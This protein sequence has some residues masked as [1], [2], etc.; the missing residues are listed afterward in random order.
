MYEYRIS[1][2]A[3]TRC[4]SSARQEKHRS[5]HTHTHTPMCEALGR[6][7]R[8]AGCIGA[9]HVSTES[10]RR[11]GRVGAPRE[12][13]SAECDRARPSPSSSSSSSSSSSTAAA[14]ETAA[15]AACGAAGA[16]GGAGVVYVEVAHLAAQ[17]DQVLHQ[18]L[19][20]RAHLLRLHRRLPVAHLHTLP[21]HLQRAHSCWHA[22]VHWCWCATPL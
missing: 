12:R 13:S 20:R 17:C 7:S 22:R 21:Q 14:A 2:T 3:A 18:T 1:G 16:R 9:E 5:T 10:R 19:H 11:G 15:A 6:A 4:V 8:R